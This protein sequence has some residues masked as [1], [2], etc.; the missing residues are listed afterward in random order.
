MTRSGSVATGGAGVLFFG[1]RIAA[2]AVTK[3]M[4]RRTDPTSSSGVCHNAPTTA[5]EI[6]RV[7]AAPVAKVMTRADCPRTGYSAIHMAN[8]VAQ[9]A[10]T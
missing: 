9:T 6:R 8:A 2:P 1:P 5:T 7:Q 10:V 3:P 4:D